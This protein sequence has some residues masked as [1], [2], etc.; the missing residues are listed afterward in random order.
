MKRLLIGVLVLLGCVVPSRSEFATNTT[1][2]IINIDK[3]RS[4]RDGRFKWNGYEDQSVIITLKTDTVTL[5]PLCTTGIGRHRVVWQA[6]LI[7]LY[8][9][10]DQ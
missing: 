7:C 3:T 8:I 10:N 6:H 9:K 5:I 1:E 2:L 4:F